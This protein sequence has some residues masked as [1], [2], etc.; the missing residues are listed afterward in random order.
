[1][2]ITFNLEMSDWLAFQQFYLK[3]SKQ[4]IRLKL[5]V[6]WM[7]PAIFAAL[8][9]VQYF[10]EPM[11]IMQAV[12]Y[13]IISLVWVIFYP[14]HFTGRVMQRAQKQM[15][16]G[17]NS[18]CLGTH[19]MSFTEEGIIDKS[20]QSEYKVTWPGIKRME[21]TDSHYFLYNS[22]LSAL[23]IPKHQVSAQL[24]ELST[25]LQQHWPAK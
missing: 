13:T 25:V 12:M 3:T 7:V 1:M 21:E 2:E 15:E 5:I 4:F 24:K 19:T 6:T 14:R 8:L 20:P 9:F 10:R 22:A 16:S 11:V 23:I 17:D 18:G